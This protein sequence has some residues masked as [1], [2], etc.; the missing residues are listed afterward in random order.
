MPVFFRDLKVCMSSMK[1]DLRALDLSTRV[2]QVNP[3]ADSAL[4]SY[5]ETTDIRDQSNLNVVAVTG[6][7]PYLNG[8]VTREVCNHSTLSQAV[9]QAVTSIKPATMQQF[10]SWNST[11]R[12]AAKP[13]DEDN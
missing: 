7:K 11:E 8:V 13:V 3:L 10:I 6:G 9:I 12:K 2:R 1:V 4:V 5:M